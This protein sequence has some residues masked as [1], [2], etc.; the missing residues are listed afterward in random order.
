MN[1]TQWLNHLRT[2]DRLRAQGLLNDKGRLKCI[3]SLIDQERKEWNAIEMKNAGIV[4]NK[5][6][7]KEE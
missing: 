1:R 2:I 6:Q 7:S 4:V 5:N 3:D